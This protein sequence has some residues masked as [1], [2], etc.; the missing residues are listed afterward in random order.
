MGDVIDARIDGVLV[1][2]VRLNG[3]EM[4]R[5]RLEDRDGQYC[6]YV[7]LCCRT[8]RNILLLLRA[9]LSLERGRCTRYPQI[10]TLN[11]CER[12]RLRLEDCDG[13]YCSYVALSVE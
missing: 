6:S 7:V 3:C 12:L 4:L 11:G 2:M 9:S 13:Q 10:P 5:L 8:K 1:L